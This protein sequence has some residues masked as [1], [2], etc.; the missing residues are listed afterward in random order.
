MGRKEGKRAERSGVEG[1]R[2]RKHRKR[3]KGKVL[4][5]MKSKDEGKGGEKGEERMGGRRRAD[6]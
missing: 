1:G 4:V 6:D 2:R 3:R 5:E